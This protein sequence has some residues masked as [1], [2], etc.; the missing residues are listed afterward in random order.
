MHRLYL[1][2]IFGLLASL[3]TLGNGPSHDLSKAIP[4]EFKICQQTGLTH[5]QKEQ[6]ISGACFSQKQVI[7]LVS[8]LDWTED[9]S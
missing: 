7:A 5:E 9:S 8:N 2:L 6:T 4:S 1:I 3:T